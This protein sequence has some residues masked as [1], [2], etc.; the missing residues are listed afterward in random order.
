MY[1]ISDPG[2]AEVIADWVE[3]YIAQAE[4]ELSKSG[5]RSYLEESSG[6]EP[7]DEQIDS[8]WLEL[9]ARERLYGPHPPYKV[10][11]NVVESIIDWEQYPEYLACLIFAVAGNP[12]EPLKSG[13]LFERITNE[14]VRN[15]IV[16]ESITVGF[17]NTMDVEEIARHLHEKYN[18]EPPWY[19][20]DRNLDVVAWKSFGDGRCSQ[21][22]VLIQCAA[23][24][25]WPSKKRELNV[26]AWCNYI[27]F[28][29]KPIKAFSI[30]VIISDRIRLEDDSTDA[31]VIIDRARIYRNIV[32]AIPED[33]LRRD[34]QNWC[35]DRLTE[36]LA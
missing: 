24:H 14:A 12:V 19:R 30:P 31:G 15:F 3:F 23:G 17:P 28:A 8:V 4:G 11:G 25:N 18:T 10:Q 35:A 33:E 5:L 20:Q 27:Q 34:V 1:S 9:E 7:A 6:L 26:D 32:Q 29:C 16:G 22:I 13:T 36:M 21:I 2:N